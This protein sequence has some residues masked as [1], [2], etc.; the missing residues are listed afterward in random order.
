[1]DKSKRNSN[2]GKHPSYD[3][4]NMSDEALE[5]KHKAD[6]KYSARDSAKKKRAE[7]NQKRREAEKAGKDI[8]GKDYDHKTNSFIKTS[9]NRGRKGEGAR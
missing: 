1:M 4:R 9:T 7:S 5:N 8:K 6:K 3:K 2:A